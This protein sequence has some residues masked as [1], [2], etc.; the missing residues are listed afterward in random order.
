MDFL[1]NKTSIGYSH[2]NKGIVCQDFSQTYIDNKYKII[3][4]CDGHGGKLYIRSERGAE[5]ASKAVIE[6]ITKYSERKLESL[7]L[8]KALDKLKLEILCKWNELVEQDYSFEHFTKEELEELTE[9]DIFKLEN[10][11]ITAY[12]TTLNATILT[13]NYLI[14]IQIGDGGMYF[15]KNKKMELVFPENDDNVANIT[16]SLCQDNV[17]NNLFLKAVINEKYNGII[18]CTDGLLGPYQTYANFYENF[19]R[20]FINNFKIIT[21]KKILEMDKFINDLGEKLGNGDDV[22]FATI[23]YAR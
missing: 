12:G 16:N 3:T 21:K 4:C 14:C 20:S 13:K 6:V 19:V 23:L 11:Y 15:I 7:V 10:N 1:Y 18:L 8:K 22:S 5:F 2:I 17:Y 9:E